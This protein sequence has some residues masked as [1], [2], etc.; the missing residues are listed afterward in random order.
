MRVAVVGSRTFSD[1]ALLKSHLDRLD[2][3]EMIVSGGAKGADS[4]AE[5]WARQNSIPTQIFRADW[6]KHGKSAGIIRNREIVANADLIVAFWDG[7][8]KGTEYTVEFGRKKG[9]EVQIVPFSVP[10]REGE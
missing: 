7:E 8:S 2:D 4:L 5:L 3:V 6:R 1:F 9:V 10:F